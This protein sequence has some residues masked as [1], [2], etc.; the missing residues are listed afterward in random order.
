MLTTD[1]TASLCSTILDDRPITQ[2]QPGKAKAGGMKKVR[3]GQKERDGGVGKVHRGNGKRKI[4]CC[5]KEIW[6]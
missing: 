4:Y 1:C 5:I 3:Y 2:L 6:E